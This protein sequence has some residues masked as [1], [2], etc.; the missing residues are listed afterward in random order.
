[1]LHNRFITFMKK[2]F[3]SLCDDRGSCNIHTHTHR[4]VTPLNIG[5]SEA[6]STKAK[7]R[8]PIWDK[9]LLLWLWALAALYSNLASFTEVGVTN[10]G[11]SLLFCHVCCKQ[12]KQTCHE[13]P[14]CPRTSSTPIGNISIFSRTVCGDASAAHPTGDSL[15]A[16]PANSA[17]S[18][19]APTVKVMRT[20]HTYSS[21]PTNTHSIKL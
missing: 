12:N 15:N 7:H 1:M 9:M 16:S 14:K 5:G 17:C 3:P 6:T 4:H 18:S 20:Q 2:H 21:P 10:P 8:D 19:P 11:F 13:A